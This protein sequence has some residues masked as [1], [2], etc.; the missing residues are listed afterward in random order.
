M[1][2]SAAKDFIKLMVFDKCVYPVRL[3]YDQLRYSGHFGLDTSLD[4]VRPVK[5]RI[6]D[7]LDT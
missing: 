3:V 5:L 6:L 7:R 1:S 4:I 2:T